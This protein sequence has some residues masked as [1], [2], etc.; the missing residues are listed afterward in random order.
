[1]IQ[2]GRG[3]T[4][5]ELLVVIA[6]IAIL[7]GILFPVFA[8]AREKA[9]QADCIS[10]V[11]QMAK[12]HVMYAQDYDQ[13]LALEYFDCNASNSYT[14]NTATAPN[15]GDYAWCYALL[16]Y[17]KNRQIFT[18]KA[19]PMDQNWDGRIGP[20]CQADG[21]SYLMNSRLSDVGYKLSRFSFPAQTVL[22]A[23]AADM[24]LGPW[25]QLPN[26]GNN[27]N[28]TAGGNVE[29]RV[30]A[31]HNGD[32]VDWAAS[33]DFDT[34]FAVV[35]YADGHAKATQMQPLLKVGNGADGNQ[36]DPKR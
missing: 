7:A 2:R 10:N 29:R 25:V 16:S 3:F 24:A 23:D 15:G 19:H 31:N 32:E 36:W 21:V 14:L 11:N 8:K 34:G 20:H 5:I 35:G 4:L 13:K 26:G 18:C 33:G 6:I 17:T 22:V 12:A 27:N 30:R 1:M 28:A 9:E